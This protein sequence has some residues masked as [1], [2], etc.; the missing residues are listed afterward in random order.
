MASPLG[1]APLLSLIVATFGRR[2]AVVEL[3]QSIPEHNRQHVE[4]VIVDQNVPPLVDELA[5]L[6]TAFRLKHLCTPLRNASAARNLGAANANAAWLMFPDDDATFEPDAL[7]QFLHLI[8]HD[9]YDLISGQIVNREGVPHLLQ[10]LEHPA[11]ITPDTIDNTLVESSFA[12]RRDRFS[13]VGGFDPLFGPGAPFPSAEGADLLRRLWRHGCLRTWFTPRI[14]LQHPARSVEI[15][16]AARERI[17]NFAIGEGAFT[18]RHYRQ[19]P[20]VDIGRKLLLR[21]AGTLV[22]S[23]EQ[24]RRKLSFLKGFRTGVLNYR[25]L[26]RDRERSASASRRSFTA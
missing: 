7:D 1:R 19:L 3:L 20:M 12:I 8:R 2:S 16:A 14:A 23:G 24:R 21:V 17:Y 22:T 5:R 11:A 9:R 13:S 18:A 6:G 26:Q 15:T 10:W 25:R 4:V